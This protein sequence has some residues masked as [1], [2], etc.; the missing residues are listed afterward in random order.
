MMETACA[1]ASQAHAQCNA[2]VWTMCLVST[3]DDQRHPAQICSLFAKLFKHGS[4]RSLNNV[5]SPSCY[6][7]LPELPAPPA[8]LALCIRNSGYIDLKFLCSST[9][10]ASFFPTCSCD[11]GP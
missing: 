11:M 6:S 1:Q 5:I 2:H 7:W 8:S 4:S 9:C 10:V 3:H